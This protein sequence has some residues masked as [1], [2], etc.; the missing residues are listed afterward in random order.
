MSPELIFISLIAA[1]YQ[2]L[3]NA[4]AE[5]AASQRNKDPKRAAVNVLLGLISS[6]VLPLALWLRM[7]EDIYA[8]TGRQECGI[9]NDVH[10]SD[11]SICNVKISGKSLQPNL[12]L[13]M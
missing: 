6:A 8:Q 1:S 9:P 10:Y 13:H 7:S 4:S 3:S 5:Q 2:C 12:R 11:F